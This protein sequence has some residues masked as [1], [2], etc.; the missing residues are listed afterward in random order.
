MLLN[1]K[2]FILLSEQRKIISKIR[3]REIGFLIGGTKYHSTSAFG[4]HINFIQADRDVRKALGGKSK[5]HWDSIRRELGIDFYE[6]LT[7][8][9][10]QIRKMFAS[11]NVIRVTLTDFPG[12][13]FIG[14]ES[15]MGSKS[16]LKPN[17]AGFK[18]VL[19]K[20]FNGSDPEINKEIN[21]WW[22]VSNVN[23]GVVVDSWKWDSESQK[24]IVG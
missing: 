11:K 19:K 1:F 10:K 17:K 7:P 22:D 18:K 8:T 5:A 16:I 12:S 24:P 13:G 6:G 3:K 14:F 4:H 15:W 21:V 2:N 20:I 9:A 23:T